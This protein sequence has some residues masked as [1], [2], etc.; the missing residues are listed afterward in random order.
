MVS[1]GAYLRGG[2]I[3]WGTFKIM[4]DAYVDVRNDFRENHY[5]PARETKSAPIQVKNG[6]L[7]EYERFLFYRGV[8]DFDLPISI[9]LEENMVRITNEYSR[10]QL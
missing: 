9:K 2:R 6:D 3:D 8:G 7:V 10:E 1:A 5:Y 4:P